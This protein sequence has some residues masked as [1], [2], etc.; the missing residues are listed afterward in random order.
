MILGGQGVLCPAGQRPGMGT[1]AS[2]PE[3]ILPKSIERQMTTSR[4]SRWERRPDERPQELLEAAFRVFAEQGYRAT[5][6]EQVAEAAGV[7]KG[8]IYYYFKGKDDLFRQTIELHR[9]RT[10]AR[11]NDLMQRV[12]GPISVRLRVGLQEAWRGISGPSGALLRLMI[13]EVSIEAPE[14]FRAWLSEVVTQGCGELACAVRE[15]QASGDFRSD[16]DADV[17]ARMFISGVL[18]EALMQHHGFGGADP[19]PLDRRVEA[20]VELFLHSLQ[21]LAP[22]GAVATAASDA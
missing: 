10:D 4:L 6:L 13:G 3:L 21:P 11:L 18:M 20:G 16:A 7:T 17:A 9:Q 22:T 12:E 19:L 14:L 2:T 5:R 1:T 15:G 8:T